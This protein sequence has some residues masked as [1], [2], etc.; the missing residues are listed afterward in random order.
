MTSF[1][2]FGLKEPI[3][4]ALEDLHFIEP[5]PIQG[6]TLGL[7]IHSDQDLIGLAQTGTGKTAA[8]SLPLIHNIEVGNKQP[9]AIILCPTRELCLQIGRDIQAYSKYMPGFRVQCVYG[10]SSIDRQIKALQRGCHLV[11]GTP[12]RTLD[13]IR[14]RKLKLQGIRWVVLDEADEMLNMGFKEDLNAILAETPEEKQTLLFSATMPKEISRMAKKYMVDPLEVSAGTKNSGA[15]NVSHEYFLSAPRNRYATLKAILDSHH[16]IYAIVF[17]RTRRETKDVSEKLGQDGYAADALHGELSQRQ[18]DKVMDKFRS[19]RLQ[20]MVATDVAARGLDVDNLTHV[21]N[22][23]LPDDPESY[24]HRSG[25]TGRAGQKGTSIVIIHA[26]E[27]RKISTLEKKL[28][29]DFKEGVLPSAKEL[30]HKKLFAYIAALE[31]TDASNAAVEEILPEAL[32]KISWLTKEDLVARMLTLESTRLKI[33]AHPGGRTKDKKSKRKRE[34]NTAKGKHE[35]G[36]KSKK[37][38]QGRDADM[39]TK[40]SRFHINIGK[41][42]LTPHTL[43][44]LVN[45]Q[46]RSD[47]FEI[48]KIEIFGSFSFFEVESAYEKKL[49]KAFQKVKFRGDRVKVELAEPKRRG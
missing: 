37:N 19:G 47:S 18:R 34:D 38:K 15:K 33:D 39:D 17:C 29:A 8:F 7:L 46:L 10:G 20:I 2:E 41:K 9:Q 32:K 36:K 5:T 16:N 28:G 43:I 26:R 23:N 44:G 42:K 21:I 3:L 11:V 27:K 25:R 40:F 49:L 12:G 14:R 30:A 4:Q 35:K 1:A 13:M 22:F 6:K 48:G 45:E 31:K 24:I